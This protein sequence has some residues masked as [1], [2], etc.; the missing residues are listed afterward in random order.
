[1]STSSG[2][3]SFTK[4][5]AGRAFESALEYLVG[6]LAKG[7]VVQLIGFGNFTVLNRVEPSGRRVWKLIRAGQ[8]DWPI[9]KAGMSLP[10]PR[11]ATA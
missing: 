8:R 11:A 3:I 10:L 1:M 7:E 4:A 6:A 5:G 9:A 2:A